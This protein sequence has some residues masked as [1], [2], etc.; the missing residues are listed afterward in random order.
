MYHVAIQERTETERR[1]ASNEQ[2]RL[3]ESCAGR[4]GFT[5]NSRHKRGLRT[6]LSGESPVP[7][8]KAL[9]PT[10]LLGTRLAELVKMRHVYLYHISR[11]NQ[12]PLCA[13]SHAPSAD[14]RY[15]LEED[16]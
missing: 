2:F 5:I 12:G 7:P 9:K 1:P 4:G 15:I 11:A 8:N 14:H 3:Q 6:T 16:I 10:T 13:A